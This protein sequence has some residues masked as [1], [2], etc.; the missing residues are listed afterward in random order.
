M[1]PRESTIRLCCVL[2]VHY[3]RMDKPLLILTSIYFFPGFQTYRK[4]RL[5]IESIELRFGKWSTL[6]NS[7]QL[8]SFYYIRCFLEVSTSSLFMAMNIVDNKIFQPGISKS[9]IENN[10]DS[11][12][13]GNNFMDNDIL[14]VYKLKNFQT[15]HVLKMKFLKITKSCLTIVL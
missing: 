6:I 3:I 4:L 7:D 13:L 10:Q 14:S 5:M 1:F 12:S 9:I 8:S 11:R 2:S 15:L